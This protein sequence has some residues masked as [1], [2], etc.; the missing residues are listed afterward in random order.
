MDLV[1]V[2]RILS[3]LSIQYADATSF[4]SIMIF[5]VLPEHVEPLQESIDDWSSLL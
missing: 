3:F 5:L 4:I 2:P 1:L